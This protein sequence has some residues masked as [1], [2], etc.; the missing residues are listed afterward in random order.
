MSI[1]STDP[2]FMQAALQQAQNAQLVGEV[3]VGAVVVRNGR[4][5]GTG[6][7]QPIGSHDPTSHAEIIALRQ[8]AQSVGNYR[9]P[10]CHLYVTLEP[11]AM[12]VGAM[13][14]ARLQR[15]VFG[16]FDRKTGAGGS[17]LN[18]F[19]EVALNHHTEAIGGVMAAE[20][21]VLLRGF[22]EERRQ[23]RAQTIERRAAAAPSA[24]APDLSTTIVTDI[25]MAEWNAARQ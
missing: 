18:L 6:F 13:L 24:R 23:K 8:A 7:N 19:S 1:D 21:V 10:D 4:I 17:V 2:L 22:F 15:V 14:H 3:P 12:C 5:I 9:L 20:S 11:C 25:D 16:A